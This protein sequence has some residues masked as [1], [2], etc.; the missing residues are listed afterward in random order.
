MVIGLN[1]KGNKSSRM[2]SLNER[3]RKGEYINKEALALEFGVKEKTIQ[4]DIDSLRNYYAEM[5]ADEGRTEI[6]Y[7]KRRKGYHLI[8][9]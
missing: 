5:H 6:R 3:L 7:D 2:L 1:Y 4:R 9:W 8:N